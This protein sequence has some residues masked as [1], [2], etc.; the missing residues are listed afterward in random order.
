MAACLTDACEPQAELQHSLAAKHMLLLTCASRAATSTPFPFCVA[1]CKGIERK[2]PL[3]HMF[4]LHRTPTVIT[5]CLLKLVYLRQ[6][7]HHT[8]DQR[9]KRMPGR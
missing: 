5:Q 2:E 6:T 9:R 7:V 3:Y 4:I 8:V 1:L